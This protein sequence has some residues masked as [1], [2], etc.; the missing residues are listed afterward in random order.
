VTINKHNGESIDLLCPATHVVEVIP[1]DTEGLEFTSRRL[2]IGGA[3][4]VTVVTL[5]GETVTYAG[6]PAGT[7]LLVRANQVCSTGTS[8]TNIV[9]EY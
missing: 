9:S 3:G 1:S 8:A 6:V 2:W 7:Y 5:G 4:S